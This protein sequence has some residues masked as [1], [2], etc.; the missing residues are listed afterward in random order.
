MTL[1]LSVAFAA[2]GGVAMGL[3]L[4]NNSTKQGHRPP[5]RFGGGELPS[6]YA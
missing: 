6:A 2:F 4:A 3:M 1:M 5:E